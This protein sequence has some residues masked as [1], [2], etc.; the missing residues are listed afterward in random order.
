MIMFSLDTR[1]SPNVEVL[2]GLSE[3]KGGCSWHLKVRFVTVRNNGPYLMLRVLENQSTESEMDFYLFLQ[4]S[5]V[6]LDKS[7]NNIKKKSVT[8]ICHKIVVLIFQMAYP[9]PLLFLIG[10]VL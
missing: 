10:G 5:G 2:L 1:A 3:E 7:K 4:K 8:L 9:C 6:S